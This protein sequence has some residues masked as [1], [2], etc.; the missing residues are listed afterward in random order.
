MTAIETTR[1]RSSRSD[2]PEQ[3]PSVL[4][5]GVSWE[6]YEMLLKEVEDQ[7]LHINYD[8]GELEF[9]PPLPIHES[10]KK[11]IGSLVEA[12][13][14]ELEIPLRMLGSTTF[15]REAL[16]KGLEPD[17]C[18]YVQNEPLL[19]G[20]V[21]LDLSV[22]PPPDLA[23]EIDITRSSID[24]QAIYASLKVPEVW[25]FNAKRLEFL[26]LEGDAYVPHEHSRAFPF[27][28]WADLERFLMDW[29]TVDDTTFVRRFRDWVRQ[30][31]KRD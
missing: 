30:N 7:H 27:L 26:W 23:I 24:R 2:E 5:H 25:R 12:M 11:V 8:N 28:P 22:D 19:R 13:A 21:D 14:S 1:T 10:W 29:G 9:M 17:E 20:R 6:C 15:R 18:Y 31:L 16:A 3:R 4:L